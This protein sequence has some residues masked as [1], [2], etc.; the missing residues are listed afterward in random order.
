MELAPNRTRSASWTWIVLLWMGLGIFDATQ[1]IVS[2]RHAQMHHA[3]VRLFIVLT[4]TWLPWALVTPLVIFLGRRFPLSLKAMSAWCVHIAAVA[5]ID[6][7]S[8]A[9]GAALDLQMQPWVPDF[10]VHDFLG[11]WWMK[12][13]GGALPAVILYV[14]ILA[15]TY[16]LDARTKASEQKTQAARLNEQLSNAKLDALQRQLEPHFLFN[17]L[18]SIS[19][20]VRE[21]KNA[22]AVSMIAALSELLRRLAATSKEPTTQLGKE[23]EF[24][25]KYLQIQETRFADRLNL[26]LAIPG[27]LHGAQVPSLILQPIVENAIKHGIAKRAQGGIVRIAASRT[28]EGSSEDK[29]SLSVYNDGPSLKSDESLHEGVGLSN[30]RTRLNLLYGE[31]FELR[32]RN[33]GESGVEVTVTLPYRGP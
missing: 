2:M 25:R 1:N 26:Q 18:N 10:E 28:R 4:I 22:D 29:L 11:T 5:A 17:T 6:V 32:L 13:I 12:I 14:I 23:V 21:N 27:S 9:W 20:L 16:A 30:L 24:L 3:W 15:V 8:A 33:S 31:E 19:G 7:V